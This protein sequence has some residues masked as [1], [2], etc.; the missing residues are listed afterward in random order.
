MD[1]Y[2]FIWYDRFVPC[3]HVPV[4]VFQDV[5]HLH[6]QSIA[7][8]EIFPRWAQQ[9]SVQCPGLALVMG[10]KMGGFHKWWYP[11]CLVYSGKFKWMMTGGTPISG[12]QHMGKPP[13]SHLFL[14]GVSM[15]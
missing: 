5:L 12:N 9:G 7:P 14:L 13:S 2:G 6:K 10:S 11:K 15:Q 3:C 4:L 8:S 1:Y